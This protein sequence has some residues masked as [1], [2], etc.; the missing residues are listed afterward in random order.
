MVVHNLNVVRIPGAPAKTDS[1][2]LVDTD[3]VLTLSNSLELFQTIP[4]WYAEVIEDRRCIKHS[5][6]PERGSL[7]CGAQFLDG[8]SPE[9]P[10]SVTVAEALDHAQ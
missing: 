3:A 10:F 4:R 2:L 6:L 7:D 1:P 5:E 8:L 9:E